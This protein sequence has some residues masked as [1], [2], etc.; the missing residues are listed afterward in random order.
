MDAKQHL[1]YAL[2]ALAYAVAKADGKVQPE[3]QEKVQQIVSSGTNHEIDFTYTDIIFKLLQQDKAGFKEVY[4]WAMHSFELGKYHFTA[5]MKAGFVDVIQQ[6]ADAYPPTSAEER[7]LIER[8]GDDLRS[9]DVKT[10]I[11]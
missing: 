8:F 1:Y 4:N 7:K 10:G 5:E 2:G 6:V 3:E 11:S 9:L